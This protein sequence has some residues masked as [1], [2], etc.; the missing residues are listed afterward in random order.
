MLFKENGNTQEE[1]Q[2]GLLDLQHSA[3][4]LIC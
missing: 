3:D 1:D 4:K 2:N